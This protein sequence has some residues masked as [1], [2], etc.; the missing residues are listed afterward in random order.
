MKLYELMVKDDN[1]TGL[2]KYIGPLFPIGDEFYYAPI[3]NGFK[4]IVEKNGEYNVSENTKGAII[5]AYN[6]EFLGAIETD[7][8]VKSKFPPKEVDLN[9]ITNKDYKELLEKI[10]KFANTDDNRIYIKQFAY[11]NYN[12]KID[13]EEKKIN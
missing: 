8:L 9:K 4:Y 7:E 11:A 3:S 12:N 13:N 6:D 5:I 1:P 2:K 10:L